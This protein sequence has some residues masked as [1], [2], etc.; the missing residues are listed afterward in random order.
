MSIRKKDHCLQEMELSGL[1]KSYYPKLND[2]DISGAAK[3]LEKMSEDDLEAV[4]DRGNNV[5]KGRKKLLIPYFETAS[6]IYGLVNKDDFQKWLTLVENASALSWS[7]AESFFRSSIVILESDSSLL[8][9]WTNIGF[10]LAKKDKKE[11]LKPVVD[12]FA[13]KEVGE[14]LS[15]NG[16][17]PS[18]NP[19][20]DN[21]ISSDHKYMWIGWDYI[22][23]NDIGQ[24]IEKCEKI[25]NDTIEV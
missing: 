23:N 1:I 17:F 2:S 22:K 13:S 10:L 11:L 19:D 21:M 6:K 7:C 8:D 16:K 4:L 24:L 3:Y 25:F 15:H 5:L 14:I 9:K 12:F 18:V 20:V